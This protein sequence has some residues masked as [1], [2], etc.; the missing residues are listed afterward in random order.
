MTY[1]PLAG[2]TLCVL[3]LVMLTGCAGVKLGTK[4]AKGTVKTGSAAV[5]TVM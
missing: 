5:R 1:Q 3:A 2:R 4:A